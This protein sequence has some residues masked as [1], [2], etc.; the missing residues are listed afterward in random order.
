MFML[1]RVEQMIKR[2]ERVEVGP[3]LDPKTEFR[4]Q[5]NQTDIR[6]DIMTRLKGIGKHALPG[7][8]LTIRFQS[9][10]SNRIPS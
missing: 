6:W 10:I 9:E 1:P 2:S 8:K 3:G 5:P 4:E 7:R